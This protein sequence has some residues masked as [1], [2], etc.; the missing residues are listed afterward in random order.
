V[1][2]H[3]FRGKGEKEGV[4]GWWRG[5]QEGGQHLNCK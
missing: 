4:G 1:G 3:P 2:E 5:D